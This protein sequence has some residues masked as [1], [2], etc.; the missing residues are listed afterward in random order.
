MK[1]TKVEKFFVRSPL[2]VYFQRKFEAPGVLANL[3][4]AEGSL[5]LEIGCGHGAGTLLINQYLC[6]KLVVGVDIDPDMIE[7]AR[8]YIAHPPQWARQ[9][10]TNNIEFVCQ[11]ATRLSFPDGYFDAAFLFATLEHI[12]EWRQAL[13]EVSRVLKPGG[14]FSFEEFLLAESS[15]YRFGHVIIAEAELRDTLARTGFS[16]RGFNKAKFMSS[17]YFIKAVKNGYSP[18]GKE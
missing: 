7:A 15:G 13:A 11:D 18:G 16:I 1:M 8:R 3:D 17:R 14:V 6:P 5:C 9:T 10:R 12:T 2:R 4:L